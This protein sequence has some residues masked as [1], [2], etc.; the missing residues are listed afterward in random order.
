M[1]T[2]L[3]LGFLVLLAIGLRLYGIGWG[4]PFRLHPDAAK[5]VQ[6]AARCG[7][8]DFNPR[9]FENPSGFTYPLWMWMTAVDAIERARG[10][11][12]PRRSLF[13]R[14]QAEPY[15][16]E[17][18]G[19]WFVALI[20]A[21]SVLL[22]YGAARKVTGERAALVAALL[23]AVCFLH[24]R[25]S[26]YA[27]ND[28]PA[29]AVLIAST[30]FTVAVWQSGRWR[31]LIIASLLAGYATGTK[32][33]MC[34]AVPAIVP[35]VLWPRD[36]A[37]CGRNNSPRTQLARAACIL[38]AGSGLGFLIACPYALLDAPF[39]FEQLRG[40]TGGRIHRWEGQGG[41]PVWMLMTQSLLAGVGLGPFVVSIAALWVERHRR[42][43]P[44][45]SLA[46]FWAGPLSLLLLIVQPLFFARFALPLVPFL[47]LFTGWAADRLA[48]EKQWRFLF[49]ALALL[50]SAESLVR[51]VRHGWICSHP[52]TRVMAVSLLAERNAKTVAAD[53]FALP[54]RYRDA[55]NLVWHAD[56]GEKLSD[57]DP[58]QLANDGLPWFAISSFAMH[59]LETE[60]GPE[61][62]VKWQKRLMEFYEP[63]MHISPGENVP[64]HLE[65]SHTP[66]IGLF[67]T[68]NPGPEIWIL[69]KRQ[70]E[71]PS[72]PEQPLTDSPESPGSAS[73]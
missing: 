36:P 64:Y 54:F 39:F 26:R 37:V 16:L 70:R 11:I 19:R 24:V 58:E 53:H 51:S 73:Q 25:Q 32:Y 68:T 1:K 13:E 9:Y 46:P 3:T 49:L 47:A 2:R 18:W 27:V 34:A 72:T 5:Y 50:V 33:T 29:V 12:E 41:I 60:R 44:W 56:L 42:G 62:L 10:T 22:V 30:W 57:I 14:Y 31:D 61:A 21:L 71:E 40:L 8:G 7:A 15:R 20:G 38:I 63:A 67:S 43:F 52:D 17:L 6:P 69:H 66:F 4:M 55:S 59:A 48:K 23:V 45:R 28:I 65:H 35:A